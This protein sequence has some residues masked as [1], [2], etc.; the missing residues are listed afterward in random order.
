MGY[1]AL[2]F[3]RMDD[4]EKDYRIKTQQMEFQWHP[5]FINDQG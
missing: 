3:A 1:E 4:K 5:T 2:F